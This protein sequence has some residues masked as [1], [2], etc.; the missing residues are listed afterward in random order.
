MTSEEI[1]AKWPVQTGEDLFTYILRVRHVLP[2]YNA[3]VKIMAAYEMQAQSQ[4]CPRSQNL[5]AE[6]LVVTEG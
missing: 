1:A 4:A 6:P 5:N 2:E 3:D